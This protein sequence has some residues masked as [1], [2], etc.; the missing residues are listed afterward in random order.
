MIVKYEI[1][2]VQKSFIRNYEL[3]VEIHSVANIL[4]WLLIPMQF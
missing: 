2:H 4:H 3:G 1:L